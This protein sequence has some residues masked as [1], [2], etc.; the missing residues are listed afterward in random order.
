MGKCGRI[1]EVPYRLCERDSGDTR[2]LIHQ[3]GLLVRHA[4]IVLFTVLVTG[5]NAAN[6]EPLLG[7]N[8]VPE[9]ARLFLKWSGVVDTIVDLHITGGTVRGTA[10][11]RDLREEVIAELPRE[12][13]FIYVVQ[14]IGR[15]GAF[16]IQDPSPDNGYEA[17]ISVRDH[18]AGAQRHTIRAF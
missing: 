8:V 3:E 15:R 11:A 4:V 12:T 10:R 1:V 7:R 13:A 16:V 5:S 2:H 18:G 6:P 14:D 17:I 9:G